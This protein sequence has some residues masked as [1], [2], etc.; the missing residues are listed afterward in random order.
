MIIHCLVFNPGKTK[1]T[2]DCRNQTVGMRLILWSPGR[3]INVLLADL[4]VGS[5]L[6]FNTIDIDF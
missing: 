1:L 4:P 2:L 3:S 6:K 5:R